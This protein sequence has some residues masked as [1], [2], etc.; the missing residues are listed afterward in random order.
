[1]AV[2]IA[3]DARTLL[4]PAACE[5]FNKAILQPL[6][7]STNFSVHV[8]ALIKPTVYYGPKSPWAKRFPKCADL[9]TPLMNMSKSFVPGALIEDAIALLS[10]DSRQLRVMDNTAAV[11]SWVSTLEQKAEF[12]GCADMLRNSGTNA[13]TTALILS[14]YSRFS[15]W[16]TGTIRRFSS[17]K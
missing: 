5:A 16:K 3:G 6:M 15:Q 13:N 17:Q 12:I 2:I 1:M 8:F 10:A 11:A 14:G 7:N 4:C 9:D